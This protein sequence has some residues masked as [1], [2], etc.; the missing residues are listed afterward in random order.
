MREEK[1][2]AL[3]GSVHSVH[4]VHSLYLCTAK[5]KAV[6]AVTVGAVVLFR[7][8]IRFVWFVILLGK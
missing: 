8:E 1:V 7:F 2:S 3:T 6:T 5:D 4:S